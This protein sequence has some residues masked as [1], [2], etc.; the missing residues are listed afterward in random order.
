[1]VAAVT[2]LTRTYAGEGLGAAPDAAAPR[3][4][5]LFSAQVLLPEGADAH[6]ALGILRRLAE[7]DP[8]LHVRWNE[9]LG[10][11]HL[12]LM[13]E[14]QREVL[15]SV[16]KSRF[17]L[18]ASFGPADILYKETLTAPVEGVGHYEPLRH[19][20]EVHLLLEPLPAGSGLRFGSDCRTDALDG[21][22]QRQI[23]SQLGEKEHLGV[24][25][26]APLT[27][28]K[29]TLLAGRAHPKHTEGGDFREAACRAVRQGLET[30]RA[31]GQMQLL[32]P[33]LSFRL[34]VPADCVGRAMADLQR[35]AASFAPPVPA[36]ALT[37]LTGSVPA[38]A[39][40]DYARELAGYTRGRGRFSAALQGYAPCHDAQAVI[41]AAGY[42]SERD[43]DNPADSIF[44]AHGAGYLVKW[45]KVPACAHVQTG[46]G[47]PA[48]AAAPEAVSPRRVAAYCGTLAEDRELLAIFEQTYGPIRRDVRRAF[49]PAEPPAA[50]AAPAAPVPAGPEYLLVDGYNVLY[51]WDDLRALAAENLDAARRRLADILCNYRGYRACEVILVF[52]AYRVPGGTGSVAPYHNI[53]VVYTKEAETAD[54]YIERVTHTLSREHRVRVVTSDGAEQMIIL[55]NGALRVP[56]RIFREEVDAVEAA[57][58]ACLTAGGKGSAS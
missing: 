26:G 49:R 53:S 1:M 39:C 51:A 18:A 10:Q 13:G 32:E 41:A 16:L 8:A 3:L 35:M 9:A 28:V 24:L 17:G 7:E 30:A 56:A 57:I 40:R 46:W 14:V 48:A 36:G 22:W 2:G 54:T 50:P 5:P 38:A 6:A 47:R 25:T 29:I 42:E 44:C 19:Y 31:A 4:A 27:D 12:Q 52:D 23:L 45:S 43:L 34:E 37:V 15:Q 33:W 21:I 11:I 58:R 20:A 55:G